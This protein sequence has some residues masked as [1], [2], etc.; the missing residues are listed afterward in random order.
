[1]LSNVALHA[2]RETRRP[3]RQQLSIYPGRCRGCVHWHGRRLAHTLGPAAQRHIGMSTRLGGRKRWSPCKCT[4]RQTVA[5]LLLYCNAC[6]GA[7]GLPVRWCMHMHTAM[8]SA[9]AAYTGCIPYMHIGILEGTHVALP[10]GR[11]SWLACQP[12]HAS[13]HSPAGCRSCDMRTTFPDSTITAAR[14]P[15]PSGARAG[16]LSIATATALDCLTTRSTAL[17]ERRLSLH[18]VSLHHQLPS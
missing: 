7:V 8:R 10:T 14:Q 3:L 2:C 16:T 11:A 9:S 1:M 5:A 18:V 4:T 13:P 6:S 17:P 12:P 15:L